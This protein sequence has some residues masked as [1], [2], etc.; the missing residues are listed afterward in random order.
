MHKSISGGEQRW[1]RFTVC[2]YRVRRPERPVALTFLTPAVFIQVAMAPQVAG[3][4]G[5]PH[6][7]T[8]LGQSPLGVEGPRFEPTHLHDDGPHA[9]LG[10]TTHD[11]IQ[12]NPQ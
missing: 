2:L 1:P 10:D 7:A 4:G 9:A 6:G 5:Q 11:T 3:R 12:R 8:A